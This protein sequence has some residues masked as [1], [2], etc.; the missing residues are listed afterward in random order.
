[1]IDTPAARDDSVGFYAE[2]Q[3]LPNFQ[4]LGGFGPM[5]QENRKAAGMNIIRFTNIEK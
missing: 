2:R 1:M 5:S 3:P 4:E